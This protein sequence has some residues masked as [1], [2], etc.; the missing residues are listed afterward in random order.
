MRS[1]IVD[2]KRH[3]AIEIIAGR[4]DGS[5]EGGSDIGLWYIKFRRT[6]LIST[7]HVLVAYIMSLFH[8]VWTEDDLEPITTS[9]MSI[10][11]VTRG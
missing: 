10:I 3:G 7:F 11:A 9:N 6:E 5:D 4:V 1:W 8:K 2:H